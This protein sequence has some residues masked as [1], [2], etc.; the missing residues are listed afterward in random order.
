VSTQAETTAVSASLHNS[1]AHLTQALVQIP[2]QGGTD[3]YHPIVHR[4]SHWLTH[5]S[6]RPHILERDGKPV[7]VTATIHGARPGPHYVLDACLDTAAIGDPAKWTHS[8]YSGVIDDGKW[9]HGRGSSDSKAAVSLFSHLAADLRRDPSQF[10][11]MLTILFDLDEH[12]G[13]F[14]GIK[15]FLDRGGRVDGVMIGYPGNDRIVTGGRGYWRATVTIHGQAAHTGSHNRPGVNAITHGAALVRAIDET[16][17]PDTGL[18]FGLPPKL[19]VTSIS[20]GERGQYSVVP[21]V[22]ELGIDARLTPGFTA[23]DAERHLQQILTALDLSDELRQ[24]GETWPAYQLPDGHPLTTAL[25]DGA[26]LHGLD[27]A[28]S[29]AGPS[30]IGCLLAGRGIPATAGFGLAYENLHG[31]DERVDLATI[32]AVYGAYRHAV[33]QLLQ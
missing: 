29:V 21:D 27:P 13:G 3:P 10:T 28:A 11:G 8:P 9:L 32:P 19:T 2:S 22:C 16:A 15:T 25:T 4:L 23:S 7:A 18:G 5:H 1:I 31:T 24:D 17:L 30:N 12:T 6:L 33:L 20:G 26:R 14:A